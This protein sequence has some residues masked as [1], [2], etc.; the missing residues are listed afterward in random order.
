MGLGW[1]VIFRPL[2][3]SAHVG[4]L[5]RSNAFCNNRLE[6]PVIA[7]STR[8]EPERVRPA[9]ATYPLDSTGAAQLRYGMWHARVA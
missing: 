9:R 4:L 3:G 2:E 7:V 8:W 6:R 5:L 1:P